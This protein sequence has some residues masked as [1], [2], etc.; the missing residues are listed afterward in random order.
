MKL[1]AHRGN[2]D[3]PNPSE[4]NNPEYIEE[5]IENAEVEQE[6]VA[7]NNGAS[8]EQEL[9]LRE[10]FKQAFNKESVNIKY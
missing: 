3:G 5:A 7:N 9:S 10:K 4:E 2:T 6:A 8:T 1:I